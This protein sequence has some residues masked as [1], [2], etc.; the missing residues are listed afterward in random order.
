MFDKD[1]LYAIFNQAEK[2]RSL[3]KTRQSL[4]HVLRGR[5]MAS[6]FYEVGSMCSLLNYIYT[7]IT[8]KDQAL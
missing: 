7:V 2:F 6:V 1:M 8:N 5:V 4:E 3:V